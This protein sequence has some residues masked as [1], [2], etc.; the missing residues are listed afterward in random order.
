MYIRITSCGYFIFEMFSHY[1]KWAV[2]NKCA[3]KIIIGVLYKRILKA[4]ST[5]KWICRLGCRDDVELDK[6]QKLVFLLQWYKY[7]MLSD[8]MKSFYIKSFC[9]KYY[10]GD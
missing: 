7:M 1:M 9:F 8:I 3:Y 6:V 10:E 2:T 4:S 5:L